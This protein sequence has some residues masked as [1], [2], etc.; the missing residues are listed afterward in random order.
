[1]ATDNGNY[2]KVTHDGR[3]SKN[4]YTIINYDGLVK[5]LSLTLHICL[6]AIAIQING[7]RRNLAYFRK[8][9]IVGTLNLVFHHEETMY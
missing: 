6:S 2:F 1:M 7:C 4:M 9:K 8:K 3:R 5:Q